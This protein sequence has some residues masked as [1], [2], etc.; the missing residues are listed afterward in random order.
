MENTQNKSP[1]SLK[2]T[3]SQSDAILAGIALLFAAVIY[4]YFQAWGRPEE[5]SSLSLVFVSLFGF[6]ALII[7]F[8]IQYIYQQKRIQ[9][10]HVQLAEQR[11]AGERLLTATQQLQQMLMVDPLT[12][13]YT[14]GFLN[15]HLGTEMARAQRQG[16]PLN[17]LVIEIQDLDRLRGQLSTAIRDGMMKEFSGHLRNSIR[18]SDIAIRL[19]DNRFLVLFTDADL[20]RAPH[21]LARL[22]GSELESQGVKTPLTFASGWTS[23]RPRELPDQFLTRLDEQLAEDLRT[24][25]AEEAIR[26]AQ[27]DIRQR[28]NAEALGRLAGKV[29]H[30]FNNLLSLVKGYSELALDCLGKSD[31]VREYLEEI[32]RAN[33]MANTLTRQ[34]LAFTHTDGPMPVEMNLNSALSDLRGTLERV[35]GPDIQLVIQPGKDLGMVKTSRNQIDQVVINLAANARE[36]MPEGGRVVVQ[37]EN[38]ELDEAFIQWHPGSRPG[39]YVCLQICDSSCGMNEETMAHIFEPFY[40]TGKDRRGN[41]LSL[42]AVYGIVKQSGGYVGVESTP[43]RG[44]T[45]SIFLPRAESLIGA[46]RE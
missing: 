16:H 40:R 10:L 41:G 27:A 35:L 44:N 6:L 43:G 37:T 21:I 4:F 7:V 46:G 22:S 19:E 38:A 36:F 3:Q 32:H 42:A 15:Q 26:Q 31:P 24:G 25:K 28:E 29:A 18:S 34:L 5:T 14:R 1:Q 45:F 17:A 13:F 9:K 12:G 11:E 8:G 23:Y 30:D 2:R 39:S 33:E 20:S